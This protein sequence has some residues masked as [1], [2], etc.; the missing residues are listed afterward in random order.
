MTRG[1]EASVAWSMTPK[2]SV[3]I[4]TYNYARFL[5]EAIESV[6][7]QEFGDF[8]LLIVDDC[9]TDNTAQVARKY[10]EMDSRAR[11]SVNAANL[12]MVENWNHCL[13]LAAGEYIKFLFGDDVLIGP[14]ALGKMV[15][16]LD[17][18]PRAALAASARIILD[19]NS[20]WIDRWTT[21]GDG[22]HPGHDAIARCLLRNHNLI[23]EP[24]A[25][26]FRKAR[27]QRGFAPAYRQLVDE[28]MW[29]H[30]LEQGDLAYTRDALCGFRRHGGQQTQINTAIPSIREQLMLVSTYASQPWISTGQRAEI[31]YRARRGLRRDLGRENELKELERRLGGAN[32]FWAALKYFL[33]RPMENFTRSWQKRRFRRR[34]GQ[35]KAD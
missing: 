3:L 24:S 19:E 23:G 15:A 34:L 1:D 11:F 8:E 2:V 27:A 31:L 29:F 32:Y 28:E 26:I 25:V 5:P 16:M 18:N 35:A 10:C 6:L 21:F 17:S 20:R 13:K 4:P 22:I 9:S 7:A 14:R 30:I 33:Q 12:G